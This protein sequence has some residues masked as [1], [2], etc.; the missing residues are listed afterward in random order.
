MARPIQTPRPSS[1]RRRSH[2]NGAYVAPDDA[3]QDF[4]IVTNPYDSQ[5]GQT[6]GGVIDMTLK[7]GTNQLHGDVYEY[8]RRTWLDAD[9]WNND[10]LKVLNPQN[11]ASGIYNTQQH[12]LDQY[13]AELDGP[14]DIPHLYN[15]RDK[16]FFLMQVENWNENEP[17]TPGSTSVPD[18]KWA[19]GDFSGLIYNNQPVT[20]YNPYSTFTDSHGNIERNPF[21]NNQIPQSMLNPT[22]VEDP[23]LL[24]Q[25]Q[26]GHQPIHAVARK[27]P[28]SGAD[29][30]PVPQR[31]HQAG[32]CLLLQ[33]QVHDQVWILG[34]LRDRHQ[35]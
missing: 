9:W 17:N 30:R 12:K 10:A 11:V 22:A 1:E 4:K 28:G 35:Q 27:L 20:I 26:P 6:R 15:G 23:L 18:P 16:T 24:S 19:T 13:G 3:V 8:L 33:G 21:P 32:P 7:T 14:V 25:A 5:Y 31:P 2:T 29:N 34:A